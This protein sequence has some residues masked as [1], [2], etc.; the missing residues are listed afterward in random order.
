MR[1]RGLLL[2]VAWGL[3]L[4][5]RARVSVRGRGVSCETVSTRLTIEGMTSGLGFGVITL[6][7]TR[8]PGL[9]RGVAASIAIVVIHLTIGR[10][11]GSLVVTVVLRVAAASTTPE[12]RGATTAASAV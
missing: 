9:L 7:G 8:V 4:L 1:E 10:I 12:A 6:R 5:R 3:L 11:P 2:R